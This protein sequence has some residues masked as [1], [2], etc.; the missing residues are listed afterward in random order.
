MRHFAIVA[1]ALAAL[2]PST[3]SAQFNR[4]Y[5]TD[6]TVGRVGYHVSV[7]YFS[8]YDH[9]LPRGNTPRVMTGSC[10]LWWGNPTYSGELP[11]GIQFVPNSGVLFSGAP[12]QPGTWRGTFEFDI[13]C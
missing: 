9:D 11:P 10:Q 13:G 5:L 4:P 12:R 8:I 6:S 7:G 3:A 1:V 2:M